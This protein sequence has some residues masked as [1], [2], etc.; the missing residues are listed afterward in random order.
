MFI[1]C[2]VVI[3]IIIVA[4]ILSIIAILLLLLSRQSLLED[5]R[6]IYG[7]LLALISSDG[8]PGLFSLQ[9]DLHQPSILFHVV[10][11]RRRH[12][13]WLNRSDRK[14]QEKR[15][16]DFSAIQWSIGLGGI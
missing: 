6:L 13:A 9:L 15:T 1:L 14:Q 2:L 5:R 4:I 16:E 11:G 12:D 8:F 3:I 10:G 7:N